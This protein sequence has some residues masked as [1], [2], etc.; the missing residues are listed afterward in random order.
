MSRCFHECRA[1]EN[2]RA[3]L[4]SLTPKC[5]YPHFKHIKKPRRWTWLMALELLRGITKGIV[6]ITFFPAHWRLKKKS[7]N[8]I[9]FWT[10]GSKKSF[11]LML[12]CTFWSRSLDRFLF[13]AFFFF[14]VLCKSLTRLIRSEELPEPHGAHLQSYPSGVG[15]RPRPWM[16]GTRGKGWCGSVG[17]AATTNTETESKRSM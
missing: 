2:R 13:V 1:C 12:I 5:K 6:P 9:F 11:W 3:H 8:I 17:Q 10:S 4:K 14:K 15:V 7:A 16:Y